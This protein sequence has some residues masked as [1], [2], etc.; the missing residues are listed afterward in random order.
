MG[1][2]TKIRGVAMPSFTRGK[3]I[4]LLLFIILVSVGFTL[5]RY[6]PAVETF[7]WGFIFGMVCMAI[8]TG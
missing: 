5:R 4:R 7:G 1:K 3:M 8:L 6:V 2:K